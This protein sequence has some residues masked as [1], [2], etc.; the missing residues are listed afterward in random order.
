MTETDN[1]KVDKVEKT[2]TFNT[3][4]PTG[5]ATKLGTYM[6]TYTVS[7]ESGNSAYVEFT[8]NVVDTE[9]PVITLIGDQVVNLCRYDELAEDKYTIM[10][11]YDVGLTLTTPDDGTYYSDYMVN[12]YW[13]FYTIIYNTEDLSGNKAAQVVRFVNVQ[14][15]AWNG[16]EERGLGQYVE[17]YPNPTKGEFYI[18]VDLPQS[19]NLV[20]RVSNMLGEQ[21]EIITENNT[22]GGLF[23]LDLGAYANG[24]YFVQLQTDDAS[25][26][27]KVTLAK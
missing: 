5:Q 26:I 10:D 1:Y 23:K 14:E 13:G 8:I 4:F 16:L 19:E 9:K 12:K 17:M 24:V 20:I 11:N 6:Y 7:D 21:L 22:Y 18:N 25:V 27:Q 2:G 3:E 15:C